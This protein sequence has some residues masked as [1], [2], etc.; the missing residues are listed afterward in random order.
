MVESSTAVGSDSPSSSP[1]DPGLRPATAADVGRLK[2]VLAEAFFDDPIFGWLIPDDA[3]RPARLRR[4]F[5]IELRHVALPRGRVWTTRDRVGAA[6][7][8]PPGMWRMPLN[9]TLFQGSTFGIHV[10]RAV[11]VSAAM[12]WHH[13]RVR[14]PHYYVRDLGVTPGSQG[15]GLGSALLA[16]TLARSDQQG[17]PTYIEASNE[18]S[19]ALYERLGFQHT[20][21]LRIGSC[22]PIWLMLRP[23]HTAER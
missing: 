8:L 21:E 19:A 10:A 3:K 6:L 9:A 18:R 11:R 7:S 23:P 22:P 2:T 15:R 13:G 5:G 1:V 4:F 16:P 17:V 12:E 20:R 14:E